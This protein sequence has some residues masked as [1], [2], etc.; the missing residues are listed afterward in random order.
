MS[1]PV[2]G[3]AGEVLRVRVHHRGPPEAALRRWLRAELPRTDLQPAALPPSAVLVVHRV[4]GELPDAVTGPGAGPG[5]AYGW[6][7]RVRADLATL[8]ERAARPA[9]GLVPPGA[10]AVVFADHAELVACLVADVLRGV[11]T[12][13]WWWEAPLRQVGRPDVGSVLGH[14]AAELPA[15]LDLLATWGL[16]AA[17]VERLDPRTCAELRA[18]VQRAHGITD[19]G[20]PATVPPATVLPSPGAVP[21]TGPPP[22]PPDRS[23]PAGA[24]G[25]AADRPSAGPPW[26]RWLGPAAVP[27]SLNAEQAVLLAVALLLRRAPG[28]VRTAEVARALRRPDLAWRGRRPGTPST[29]P[30]RTAGIAPSRAATPARPDEGAEV[31]PDRP[32]D[33]NDGHRQDPRGT[34]D[35]L[36]DPGGGPRGATPLVPSPAP[37]TDSGAAGGPPGGR[38]D[39]SPPW[40]DMDRR[41]AADSG[42]GLLGEAIRT[43]LTGVLY[44]INLIDR[45][46]LPAVA[47]PCW[48]LDELSGWA[49]LEVV[50]RAVLDAAGA[51]PDDE[52]DPLWRLLAALDGRS[53]GVPAGHDRRD[54][55]DAPRPAGGSPPGPL[56]Q[57]L[58]S[59]TRDWARA[60][61]PDLLARLAAELDV[62]P[63]DADRAL[64]VPGLVHHS[65]THIDA[66]MDLQ[67]IDLSVRLAGLDRDPG[68]VPRLGRV[69]GFAFGHRGTG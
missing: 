10:P 53:A 63:G 59:G 4:G 18:A 17:A 43:E 2:P 57:S 11:A 58:A 1:S 32:P 13:W 48:R 55:P 35:T 29:V 38:V 23:A 5:A 36:P 49:L 30:G 50:A 16:A 69:V 31:P 67:S 7:R 15:V 33:P 12:R 68:W 45:V 25:P 62:D 66:V 27:A 40:A 21:P 61:G 46:G 3:F 54:L 39:V 22:P 47:A 52:H 34:A 24:H 19:S 20:R 8:L 42:G 56:L 64:R 51:G 44:L 6:E 41:G 14:R 26:E 9:H 60:A 28:A 65:R 37:T